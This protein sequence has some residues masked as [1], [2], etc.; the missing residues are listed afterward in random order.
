M[1]HTLYFDL[2]FKLMQIHSNNNYFFPGYLWSWPYYNCIFHVQRE[3]KGKILAK[4]TFTKPFFSV[5]T[6]YN[7]KLCII[8]N[9]THQ[10]AS[11]KLP[12]LPEA[13]LLNEKALKLLSLIRQ[14]FQKPQLTSNCE[15]HN[16]DLKKINWWCE[17]ISK[18]SY[19]KKS[20]TAKWPN[21]KEIHAPN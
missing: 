15:K 8:L 12:W 4:L 11:L 21:Y 1:Y 10:S 14:L 3:A 2:I 5:E 7:P 9:S 20:I 18:P 17:N 19:W 6:L 16:S 13:F